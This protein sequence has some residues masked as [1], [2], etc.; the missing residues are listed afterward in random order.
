MHEQQQDGDEFCASVLARLTRVQWGKYDSHR[1]AELGENQEHDLS[2]PL[3]L[4]LPMQTA[5]EIRQPSVELQAQIIQW[6]EDHRWLHDIRCSQLGRG[7]ALNVKDNTP[8]LLSGFQVHIPVFTGAG[9][10]IQWR[11]WKHMRTC[12]ADDNRQPTRC[13]GKQG[14]SLADSMYI[15]WLTKALEPAVDANHRPQRGLS[16]NHQWPEVQNVASLGS[17]LTQYF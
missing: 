16:S 15:L 7:Q 2:N 8:V 5:S 9:L 6:H 14:H 13:S 11:P 17:V 4:H 12:I 3:W 1:Q 10:D